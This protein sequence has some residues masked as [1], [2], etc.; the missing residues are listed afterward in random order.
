M[1]MVWE[2]GH[3]GDGGDVT[4]SYRACEGFTIV[5]AVIG[6]GTGLG[7]QPEDFGHNH[8]VQV[9]EGGHCG[10]SGC[11]IPGTVSGDM[12]HPIDSGNVTPDAGSE[13]VILETVNT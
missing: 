8:Q 10:D 2:G 4:F 7:C 9:L 13:G 12:C 6:P 11:L 5:T 3:H 1:Y